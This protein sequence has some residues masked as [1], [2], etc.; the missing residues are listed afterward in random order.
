[1]KILQSLFFIL[2]VSLAFNL[3]AENPAVY[4]VSVKKPIDDLYLDI[5]A[6]MNDS[7]FFIIK[8][9][10]IGENLKGMAERWGEDYNRSKLTGFRSMIFCSGWYANQVSNKDPSML[11]LCPLHIT[12]IEKQ[13]RTSV[14]FNRPTLVAKQSP[15]LEIITE[16][17]N[18]VIHLIEQA[19]N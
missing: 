7:P 10:N 8:E 14:L 15:A 17:E 9:L 13:G 2:F 12:L 4:Q 18:K 11:G 3:H 1:M 5:K 16:I 6:S 19:I